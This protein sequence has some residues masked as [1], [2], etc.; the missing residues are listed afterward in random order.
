MEYRIRDVDVQE[1]FA[2]L[3]D[4]AVINAIISAVETV[5]EG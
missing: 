5:G 2:S 4:S 1:W 3:S